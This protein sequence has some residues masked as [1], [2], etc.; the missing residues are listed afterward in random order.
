MVRFAA[1]L[2][3]LCLAAAAPP[4]MA[5]EPAGALLADVNLARAKQGLAPLHLVALLSKVANAHSAAMARLG[6]FDHRGADGKR[7]AERLTDAGY[8]FLFAG[9]N[10]SAGIGNPD[11]VV[12]QWLLSH[13]H[14][15]NLLEPRARD[16][17]IGYVAAPHGQFRYYWTLILAEPARR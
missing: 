4:A 11:T 2:I 7:I 14:R 1:A 12:K 15:T 6:F 17:G 3:A 13:D 16:A 10:L 5:A 8:G 9:E